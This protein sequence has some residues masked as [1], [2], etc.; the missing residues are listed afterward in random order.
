MPGLI[1]TREDPYYVQR[2]KLD[3]RVY[4]LSFSYNEREERWYL[5]LLDETEDPII[6]GLKLVSN[7]SLLFPHRYDPR[8]PPGEL[9]VADI[10]GDGSPPK[11]TE[12][13]AGKRCQL[14]YWTRAE[15]EA[16]V[17]AQA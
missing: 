16:L 11:L 8:T 14:L 2:T 10:T 4:I 9:S 3:G 5:S 13:G 15:L 6:Q 17:A 12:L 7:W 1:S